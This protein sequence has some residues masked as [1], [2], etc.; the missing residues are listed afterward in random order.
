[1]FGTTLRDLLASPKVGIDDK[2]RAFKCFKRTNLNADKRSSM[3]LREGD[4]VTVI[5]LQVNKSLNGESGVLGPLEGGRWQLPS[6]SAMVRPVNLMKEEWKADYQF[7]TSVSHGGTTYIV[8]I[9]PDQTIRCITPNGMPGRVVTLTSPWDD[10]WME[11]FNRDAPAESDLFCS[12]LLAERANAFF[13]TT[14][15]ATT[16][17]RV[18]VP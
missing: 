14:N 10:L 17:R 15:P 4:T 12:R 8:R 2:A 3:P 11:G 5:G 18:P 16:A 6:L 1:M 9:E 7:N 13:S